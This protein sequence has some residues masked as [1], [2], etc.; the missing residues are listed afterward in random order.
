VIVATSVQ[1]LGR[2]TQPGPKARSV[3]LCFRG[4]TGDR[5]RGARSSSLA[6]LLLKDWNVLKIMITAIVTVRSGSISWYRRLKS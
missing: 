3:F 1:G 2:V 5:G 4:R 6:Q